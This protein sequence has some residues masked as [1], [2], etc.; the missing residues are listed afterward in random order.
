MMIATTV[1]DFQ[2]KSKFL[3]LHP[4]YEPG[5]RAVPFVVS[6]HTWSF[7]LEQRHED[8]EAAVAERGWIY[9]P[10]VRS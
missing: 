6:L 10:V 7:D 5:A 4:G 2:F 3:I 8:L 1:V 9:L